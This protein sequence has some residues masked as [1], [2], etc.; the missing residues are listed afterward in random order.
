MPGSPLLL[1]L[2]SELKKVVGDSSM[3]V[4]EN[5]VFVVISKP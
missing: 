5:K 4:T 1:G 2:R 3:F